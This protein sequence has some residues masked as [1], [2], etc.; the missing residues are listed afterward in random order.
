MA[1]PDCKLAAADP[2][3][4]G[5]RLR[6]VRCCARLVVSARRVGRRHQEA[7]LLSIQRCKSAPSRQQVLDC[8]AGE[9]QV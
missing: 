1:C 6:C 3:H 4:G 7:M 5:Y 9:A 2:G 8:V